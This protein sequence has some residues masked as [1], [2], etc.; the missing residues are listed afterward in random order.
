MNFRK[1]IVKCMA[2][3]SIFIRSY[4][5]FL[6]YSKK[7]KKCLPTYKLLNIMAKKIFITLC[8]NDCSLI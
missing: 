1:S 4:G 6:E 2:G 3:Y 7:T 5:L 8:K